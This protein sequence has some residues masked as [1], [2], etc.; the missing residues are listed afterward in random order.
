MTAL[1]GVS[2]GDPGAMIAGLT[3]QVMGMVTQMTSLMGA[4]P[5]AG[6]QR[7]LWE[8]VEPMNFDMSQGDRETMT[9]QQVMV[10]VRDMLNEV[11]PTSDRRMAEFRKTSQPSDDVESRNVSVNVQVNFDEYVKQVQMTMMGVLN[12]LS[13]VNLTQFQ[14]EQLPSSGQ[15]PVDTSM[16][17]EVMKDIQKQLQDIWSQF[18]IQ[19]VKRK[20]SDD[21][22]KFK[23]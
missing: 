8:T 1:N 9:T 11:M 5:S 20:S 22:R 17:V 7:D 2:G 21:W 3:Q 6:V 10:Q 14:I 18:K 4:P 16:T 13:K 23:E 15:E 12:Q 19:I